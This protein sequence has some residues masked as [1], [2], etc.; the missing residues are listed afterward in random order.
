MYPQKLCDFH[1]H[2]ERVICDS[3][4]NISLTFKLIFILPFIRLYIHIGILIKLFFD[5]LYIL[6][7]N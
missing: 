6:T 2:L 5:F 1:I 4:I 3:Y 7:D